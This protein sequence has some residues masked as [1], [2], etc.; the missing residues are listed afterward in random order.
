MTMNTTKIPPMHHGLCTT[1]FERT[2]EGF[3]KI[4]ATVYRS[5][6]E[7]DTLWFSTLDA[8]KRWAEEMMA[9]E[10]RH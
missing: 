8:A 3:L 1:V 2:T 5:D 4:R 9:S 7:V 10:T 6:I